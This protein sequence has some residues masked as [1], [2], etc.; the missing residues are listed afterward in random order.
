MTDDYKFMFTRK[1]DMH[2]YKN[3]C[4]VFSFVMTILIF[5]MRTYFMIQIS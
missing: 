5:C 1:T 3:E 2:M 4:S